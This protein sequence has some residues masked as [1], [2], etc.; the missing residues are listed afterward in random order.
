MPSFSGIEMKLA[1]YIKLTNF[2]G[3]N[4]DDASGEVLCE[5]Y[6]IN[7]PATDLGIPLEYHELLKQ[8]HIQ[9]PIDIVSNWGTDDEI[10]FDYVLS[11]LGLI[12]LN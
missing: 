7:R 1:E 12:K 3:Y 5:I 2:T 8:E 10:I 6:T 4:F 11:V 9:L